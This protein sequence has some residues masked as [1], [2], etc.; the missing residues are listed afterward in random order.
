[1]APARR[2]IVVG[3]SLEHVWE[4]IEDPHHLPRW[5]PGVTRIEDV[6]EDRWT[7]VLTTRKGR[8]VRVD[9]RLLES[10]PPGSRVD[11]LARRRWEQE[12]AGTPFE[13]VLNESITELRLEPTH[14]QGRARVTIEQRQK[15]RGYSRTGGLIARRAS[16]GKLDQALAGLARICDRD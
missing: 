8:T 2:S 9:F 4:V 6:R 12:I 10:E 3:A 5:W 14:A 1:M 13:R 7:Q 15:L 16:G 11:G